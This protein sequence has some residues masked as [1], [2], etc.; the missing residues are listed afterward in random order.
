MWKSYASDRS[1]DLLVIKSAEDWR[2]GT[3]VE[4]YKPLVVWATTFLHDTQRAEDIVQ[5]FFV[6]LWEKPYSALLPETLKSYLFTS[7]RNLALNQLDKIDPLRRACDVAYYDSPWKEYDNF[8][9]EVFR[10]VEE[11]LEKLTPRAQD[12]IRKIYLEGM[13][14]KDVADKLGISVATVNSILVRALKKLRQQSDNN[15]KLAIYLFFLE[16]SLILEQ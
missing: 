7:I 8:E 14:Y 16:K 11:E 1:R 9:D 15:D 5:D 3:S 2:D 4:Y 12:V 10:R 6:K 13:K